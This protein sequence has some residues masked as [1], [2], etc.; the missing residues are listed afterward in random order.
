MNAM[1]V[2]MK[3]RAY[4]DKENSYVYKLM[5]MSSDLQENRPWII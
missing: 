1:G 4:C 3:Y 5:F 2:L